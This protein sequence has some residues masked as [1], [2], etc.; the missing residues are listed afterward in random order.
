MVNPCAFNPCWL[1]LHFLCGWVCTIKG[2]VVLE[3][4][5][6]AGG[7]LAAAR[8]LRRVVFPILKGLFENVLS[9]QVR[10]APVVLHGPVH[11]WIVLTKT[12]F[13]GCLVYI[14]IGL[15]GIIGAMFEVAVLLW[16]YA[17]YLICTGILNARSVWTVLQSV[18]KAEKDFGKACNFVFQGRCDGYIEDLKLARPETADMRKTGV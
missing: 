14:G 16:G 15:C 12:M 11:E 4:L 18:L 13:Y 5:L 7:Y 8:A 1:L 6:L 10:S 2:W 9:Y 3:S 17:I